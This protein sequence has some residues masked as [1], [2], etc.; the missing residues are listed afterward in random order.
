M[1]GPLLRATAGDLLRVTLDNGLPA[2]TTVH[3]HGIAL[4]NATADQ[5]AA[6]HCHNIYHAEAGMM[7]TLSYRA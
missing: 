6:A 5:W 2:D 7:T 3:W 1:P 4:R